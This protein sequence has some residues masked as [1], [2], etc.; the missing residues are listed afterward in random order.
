MENTP[1]TL[2]SL[3][4]MAAELLQKMPD[5]LQSGTGYSIDLFNRF[6]IFS[7]AENGMIFL[8]WT[9]LLALLFGKKYVQNFVKWVNKMQ[10]EDECFPWFFLYVILIFLAAP[11]GILYE[12]A[13]NILQ[14]LFIPEVYVIEYF[15]K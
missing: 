8:V 9:L 15:I 14:L 1:G 3:N 12:S 7:L 2:E 10:S 13:I 4:Q 5:I 6:V 11:L